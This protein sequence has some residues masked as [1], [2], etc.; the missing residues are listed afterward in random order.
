MAAGSLSRLARVNSPIVT[1]SITDPL[2]GESP[3]CGLPNEM[4]RGL[5]RVLEG[6]GNDARCR[7][8][9]QESSPRDGSDGPSR[10]LH[11]R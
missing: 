7:R 6:E 1:L 5:L 10:R 8:L 9:S 4:A 2:P 11:R 3:P